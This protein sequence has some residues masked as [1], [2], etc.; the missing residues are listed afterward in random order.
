[1]RE[2]LKHGDRSNLIEDLMNFT[3]GGL[4]GIGVIIY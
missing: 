3:I 1:M 4:A 2:E